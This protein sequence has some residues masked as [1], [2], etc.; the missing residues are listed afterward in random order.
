MFC[1]GNIYTAVDSGAFAKVFADF[2]CSFQCHFISSI[3]GTFAISE[4][5]TLDSNG[6]CSAVHCQ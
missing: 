2:K 6:E 4:P 3:P 5:R 1:R